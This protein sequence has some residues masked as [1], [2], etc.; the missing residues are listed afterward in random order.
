[1]HREAAVSDL[2][3]VVAHPFSGGE[4]LPI[5]RGSGWRGQRD[6]EIAR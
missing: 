2:R 1:V 4:P 5:R 3:R 6:V